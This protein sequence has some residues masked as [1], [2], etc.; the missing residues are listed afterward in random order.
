MTPSSKAKADRR[1]FPRK[2]PD[3]CP[4]LIEARLRSGTE[5]RVID[6]SNGGVLL[7]AG[8]QILPGARVEL[9]LVA[10]GQRWL[11]KGRIV[12]CHVAAIAPERGV[13][14]RAAL[15]FNEPVSILVE[16]SEKLP[17]T[18]SSFDRAQA[19]AVPAP[20]LLPAVS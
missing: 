16:L 19:F 7:E 17:S 18:F 20:V 14:Y 12:R 13:R 1:R 11:V 15:A 8:S 9:F 2:K 10:A 3:E 6:I 4:W 5:V